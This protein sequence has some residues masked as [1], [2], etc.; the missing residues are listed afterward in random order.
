MINDK[1]ETVAATVQADGTVIVTNILTNFAIVTGAEVKGLEFDSVQTARL[2]A[3]A[4][5]A[6]TAR[7]SAPDAVDPA[8]LQAA[9]IAVE[10]A[11]IDLRDMGVG[12]LGHANGFTVNYK[13]GSRSDIMRMGTRD[14]LRIAI[15]A[16]LNALPGGA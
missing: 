3:F 8:A 7:P 12:V 2:A 6:G 13:D 10:D 16:Y 11:L 4:I 1:G 14:G 5:L 9:H 15:A